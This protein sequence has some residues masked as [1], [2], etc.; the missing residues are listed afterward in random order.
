MIFRGENFDSGH[1]F[2][3]IDNVFGERSYGVKLQ[4]DGHG[5]MS[6]RECRQMAAY[7][8]LAAEHCDRLN[9]RLLGGKENRNA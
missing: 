7:L 5:V 3:S 2:A 4:P 8:I 6:P 9:N 1:C